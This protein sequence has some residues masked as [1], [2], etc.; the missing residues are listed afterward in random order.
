MILLRRETSTHLELI[1]AH[2]SFDQLASM[3]REG[4]DTDVASMRFLVASI[5]EA[6]DEPQPAFLRIKFGD[7]PVRCKDLGNSLLIK[8]NMAE[9][10]EFCLGLEFSPTSKPGEAHSL[11]DG[12]QAAG[13]LSVT[14][15]LQ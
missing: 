9:L 15:V 7:H 3:M 4:L 13:G 8:G 11:M 1:G 14:A 12:S 10:L 5:R 6:T 2:E